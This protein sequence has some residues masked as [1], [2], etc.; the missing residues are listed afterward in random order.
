M[1][2]LEKWKRLMKTKSFPTIFSKT[3]HGQTQTWKIETQGDKF[4]TL[5]GILNGALTT[6]A[7]TTC[8]PKNVGKK[9]ETS[10]EE[11]AVKEAKARHKKKLDEG[12]HENIKDINKAKFFEPML[13]KKWVDRRENVEFPVYSQRKYDGVRC[14]VNRDGMFSRNG[15]PIISAPHIFEQLRGWLSIHDAIFDG[16]L[17]AHKFKD[18]FEKIISLARQ[19]KPTKEDLEESAKH[20]EYHIYDF[21]VSTFPNRPVEERHELLNDIVK[22][23]K[24]LNPKIKIVYVGLDKA[25]TEDKLDELYSKYLDDGYEGQMIRIPGSPYENKRSNNLLKRKEFVDEEFELVDV[26][27][28]KGG[29]ENIASKV[30]CK[31]KDGTTFEAGMIGSHEYCAKLLREKKKY[32]GK[33]ATIIYQNLTEKGGVPRFGKMRAIRDYE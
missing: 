27:A 12:Y 9:N 3:A 25:E 7:W 18:N 10:G 23:L 24:A 5:E 22:L 15:K 14:I 21:Y 16:E 30:I 13:A 6:S 2:C 32:I 28:G 26:L 11:Q 1:I 17:Y 33:M 29:H 19:G 8:E 31:M 20:L 4:R